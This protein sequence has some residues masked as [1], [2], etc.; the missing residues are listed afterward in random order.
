MFIGMAAVSMSMSMSMS[1]S[2][3]MSMSRVNTVVHGRD[4]LRPGVS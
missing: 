3:S 4:S 2:M 1:V